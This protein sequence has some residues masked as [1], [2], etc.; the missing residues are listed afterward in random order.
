V[1]DVDGDGLISKEE[2]FHVLK[3]LIANSLTD[4]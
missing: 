1:Y 4:A 2:L 3:N